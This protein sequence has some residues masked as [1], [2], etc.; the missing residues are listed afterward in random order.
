[1]P[2]HRRGRTVFA[3]RREIEDWL[4]GNPGMPADENDGSP[5]VRSTLVHHRAVIAT[6][7]IAGLILV[8]FVLWT[9][10]TNPSPS[11]SL[12]LELDGR[13]LRV[14]HPRQGLVW[15]H[16]FDR[17]LIGQDIH[18]RFLNNNVHPAHVMTDLDG[19]GAPEVLV[20]LGEDEFGVGGWRLCC[21]DDEGDVVWA[22]DPG[23]MFQWDDEKVF[24]NWMMEFDVSDLDGDGIQEVVVYSRHVNFFP[25][26]FTILDPP[27]GGSTGTI[28]SRRLVLRLAHT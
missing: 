16:I 7:G 9:G 1:M 11:L 27:G 8:V 23:G 14:V 12:E 26:K 4:R 3:Y 19:N 22:Y 2:V 20:T 24:P 10:S 5:P 25:A 13:S 15:E 21:L 6:A 28:L 17:M 18:D